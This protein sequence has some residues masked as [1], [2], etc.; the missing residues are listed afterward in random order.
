M[1][2]DAGK[3]GSQDNN[4][5]VHRAQLDLYFLFLPEQ[6]LTGLWKCL[7]MIVAVD[8]RI[9]VQ[10]NFAKDLKVTQHQDYMWS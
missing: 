9:I 4:L 1:V 8:G 5:H 2:V 7:E 6:N 10:S 3:P